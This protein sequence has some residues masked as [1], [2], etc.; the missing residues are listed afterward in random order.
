MLDGI[1]KFWIGSKESENMSL[2]KI[3]RLNYVHITRYVSTKSPIVHSMLSV[4][5]VGTPSWQAEDR[6]QHGVTQSINSGDFQFFRQIKWLNV[7]VW[8]IFQT[9]SFMCLATQ[10]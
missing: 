4:D 8:I 5:Q 1:A 3:F 7:I 9:H 10:G 6:T 2:Q